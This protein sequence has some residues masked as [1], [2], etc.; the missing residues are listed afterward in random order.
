MWFTAFTDVTLCIFL[1]E[2]RLTT[3]IRKG[4]YSCYLLGVIQSFSSKPRALWLLQVSVK[5]W[6]ANVL[7]CRKGNL[8]IPSELFSFVCKDGI[9]TD[10]I[11]LEDDRWKPCG[12]IEGSKEILLELVMNMLT[13]LMA[14]QAINWPSLH[15]FFLIRKDL[16]FGSKQSSGK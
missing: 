13:R 14:S 7:A 10:T 4:G 11:F 3:G 9:V 12:L 2:F 16:K 8:L 15:F 5:Q 1:W 6:Q